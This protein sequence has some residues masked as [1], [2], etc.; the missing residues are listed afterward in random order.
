MHQ[1]VFSLGVENST[2]DILYFFPTSLY[3]HQR[4]RRLADNVGFRCHDLPKRFHLSK[5]VKPLNLCT[6]RFN[7]NVNYRINPSFSLYLSEKMSV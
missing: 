7:R 3:K 6:A 1:G 2:L 4:I 5:K